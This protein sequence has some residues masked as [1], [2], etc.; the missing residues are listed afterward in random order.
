MSID[1]IKPIRISSLT[2]RIEHE[3]HD[4]KMPFTVKVPVNIM[5]SP[6]TAPS[7]EYRYSIG[8]I[9]NVDV[10]DEIIK[11]AG[12]VTFVDE[13]TIAAVPLPSKVYSIPHEIRLMFRL[14]GWVLDPTK[15]WIQHF[16]IQVRMVNGNLAE[17][18]TVFDLVGYPTTKIVDIAMDYVESVDEQ[19]L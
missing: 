15:Y 10:T 4:G 5:L 9:I 8:A 11:T 14:T 19:H 12:T 16:L 3:N 13:D 17:A 7:A 6:V 18:Q 1:H 2:L